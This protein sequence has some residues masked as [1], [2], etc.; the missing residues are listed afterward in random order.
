MSEFRIGTRGSA[1]AT[2]QT[3]IVARALSAA[4][5][6]EPRTLIVKTEGDVVTGSLAALGGTGVFAA[7]LRQR[8]LDGG[9]DVAVHSLKDLPVAQPQGLVIAAIP[10]RED[11]RDV[12]VARDGHTLDNLPTG[13]V[14]GTG[15]PRRA[16]QLLAA[17][18]DLRVADIRGNVPTRLRRVKGLLLEH[19]D[20]ASVGRER[21]GDLDA[22]IL[23]GAGLDRLGLAR[24][25]TERL[26]PHVMLPA[27]GQGALAVEVSADTA[28][29]DTPLTRALEA[30]DDAATRWAVSAERAL[31]ARL[32]GG[33]AAPLGALGVL[34]RTGSLRLDAV[35]VSPDGSRSLRRHASA[36]VHDVA[37]AVALGEE[38]ADELLALG[39]ARLIAPTPGSET[40]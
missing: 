25:V 30:L 18:P 2:T 21:A 16:A 23:A 26:D 1:L 13:A 10:G 15:S 34:T 36:E 4:G 7:A 17:R 20:S 27:P 22:V 11:V 39:A 5:A 37:G 35:A 32:E 31:L 12:L 8:V 38:L 28:A 24:F 19:D 29:G 9:V 3:G 14:V 33:C 40:R 6:G